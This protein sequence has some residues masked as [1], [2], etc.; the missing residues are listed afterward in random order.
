M[1]SPEKWPKRVPIYESRLKEPDMEDVY[2][3][4]LSDVYTRSDI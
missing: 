1:V 2:S 3:N 4:A